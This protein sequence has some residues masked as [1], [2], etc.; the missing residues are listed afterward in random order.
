MYPK[1]LATLPRLSGI[2]AAYPDYAEFFGTDGAYATYS[3]AAAGSGR[4]PCTT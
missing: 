2:D 3:L 1:P 4:P